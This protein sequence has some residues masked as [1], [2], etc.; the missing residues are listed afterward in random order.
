[1]SEPELNDPVFY[2]ESDIV[3]CDKCK[4]Y[5]D[6]NQYNSYTCMKCENKIVE[7]ERGKK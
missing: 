3:E 2:D 6:H 7:Q 5:F 4:A 1:M